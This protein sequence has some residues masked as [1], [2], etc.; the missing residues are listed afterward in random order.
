MLQRLELS[1]SITRDAILYSDPASNVFGGSEADGNDPT[2]QLRS[3][4]PPPP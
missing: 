1:D 4:I 3:R 2:T